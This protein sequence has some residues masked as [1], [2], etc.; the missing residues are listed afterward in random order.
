MFNCHTF[1]RS[2]V[3]NVVKTCLTDWY[4]SLSSEERKSD[5]APRTSKADR[6]SPI[7]DFDY[8]LAK[9]SQI[10]KASVRASE[11]IQ[12]MRNNAWF[13]KPASKPDTSPF[14]LP[15]EVLLGGG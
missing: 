6:N 3:F 5:Y 11:S 2:P 1:F 12:A 7:I 8:L 14:K 15:E 9:V 4:C 10:N 13:A